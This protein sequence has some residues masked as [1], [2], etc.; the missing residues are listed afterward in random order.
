[1]SVEQSVFGTLRADA[2][3]V[4]Y[5]FQPALDLHALATALPKRDGHTGALFNSLPI[6]IK[7]TV[8]ELLISPNERM[9][10]LGFIRRSV[11][12]LHT[13]RRGTSL[14]Q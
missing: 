2:L 11:V 7:M 3:L 8:I 12:V 4:W 10:G 1:M 6:E 13:R 9:R 14:S 5:E